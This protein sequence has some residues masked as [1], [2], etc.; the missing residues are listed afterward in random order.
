MDWHAFLVNLGTAAGLGL[1][2]GVA[3]DIRI[4]L[5]WAKQDQ[6]G[7]WEMF[8]PQVA[9]KNILVAVLTPSLAIITGY[10]AKAGIDLLN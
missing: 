5:A 6:K 10:L 9:V 3:M 8:Q 4:V 7:F 1:I 2:A